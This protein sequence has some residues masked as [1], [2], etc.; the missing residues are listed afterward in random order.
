MD[1]L[2]APL[3]TFGVYRELIGYIWKLSFCWGKKEGTNILE[4]KFSANMHDF[5][6]KSV[7]GRKNS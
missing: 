2:D 3:W 6:T 5:L 4:S 7:K 1:K